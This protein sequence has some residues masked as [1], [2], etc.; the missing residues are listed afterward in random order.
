[1]PPLREGRQIA[2]A[3]RQRFS[4]RGNHLA[5][6][7]TP[8]N[9]YPSPNLLSLRSANSALPQGGGLPSRLAV[10]H[11][12][13]KLGTRTQP[14]RN[15]TARQCHHARRRRPRTLAPFLRGWPSLAAR[16]RRSERRLFPAAGRRVVAMV[17]G[18]AG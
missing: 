17:A 11:L 6:F 10:N 2:G 15:G 12:S 14:H 13:A 1:S 9:G 8:S 18:G 5:G 4:G 16:Q 3:E 7:E